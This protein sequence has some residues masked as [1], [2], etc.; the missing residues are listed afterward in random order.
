MALISPINTWLR[1]QDTEENQ[2]FTLLQR[3]LKD[4]K[5]NRAKG[6]M[7][8]LAAYHQTVTDSHC[9]IQTAVRSQSLPDVQ[10]KLSILPGRLCPYELQFHL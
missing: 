10:L 2:P 3:L 5:P 7:H 4:E 9:S 8:S 1:V 6:S